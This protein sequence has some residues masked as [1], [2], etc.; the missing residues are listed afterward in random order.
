MTDDIRTIAHEAV[1]RVLGP[2]LNG[3]ISG[4]M[5]TLI[6]TLNRSDLDAVELR[7]HI[8]TA[9]VEIIDAQ[10]GDV[11]SGDRLRFIYAAQAEILAL[12]A[13]ER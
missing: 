10:M 3:D 9:L 5:D 13:G 11:P 8:I 7:W 12:E 2:A 4:G 6:D 1:M